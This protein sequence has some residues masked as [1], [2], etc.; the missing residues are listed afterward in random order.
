MRKLVLL[1][2]TALVMFVGSSWAVPSLGEAGLETA[3]EEVSI[4]VLDRLVYDGPSALLALV[5]PL[6]LVFS[7][8]GRSGFR[9]GRGLSFAGRAALA[10]GVLGALMWLACAFWMIRA[11]PPDPAELARPVSWAFVQPMWAVAVGA[12]FFGALSLRARREEG[13][14]D[15]AGTEP[16]MLAFVPLA[17]L[18]IGMVTF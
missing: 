17:F 2:L 15:E 7:S 16:Y 3:G 5:V 12:L 13:S 14:G 11:E 6:L 9:S 10:W 18:V 4:T 8:R 1:A